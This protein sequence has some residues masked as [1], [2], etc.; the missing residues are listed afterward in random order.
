MSHTH[1]ARMS[2]RL[3]SAHSRGTGDTDSVC[4]GAGANTSLVCRRNAE[5]RVPP[6]RGLEGLLPQ[7][8]PG[9]D[10]TVG[11][12]RCQRHSQHSSIPTQSWLKGRMQGEAE[13]WWDMGISSDPKIPQAAATGPLCQCG[14]TGAPSAGQIFPIPPSPAL[15]TRHLHPCS[16]QNTSPSPGCIFTPFCHSQNKKGRYIGFACLHEPSASILL[17]KTCNSSI[18]HNKIRLFLRCG[19]LCVCGG[20]FSPEFCRSWV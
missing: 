17:I 10:E 19:Q 9:L 15:C 2:A 5:S 3:V 4:P 8:L 16:E 1:M 18:L 11:K 14:W 7:I 12:S 20:S 6:Q 13:T